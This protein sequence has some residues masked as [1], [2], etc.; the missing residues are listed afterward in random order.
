MNLSV[1]G[2]QDDL[3]V[4]GEGGGLGGGGVQAAALAWNP[5]PFDPPMI[6]VAVGGTVR[7]WEQERTGN[8]WRSVGGWEGEAGGGEV[9]DVAW[10][11]NMGRSYHL[12][13]TA[14]KD[15]TVRVY[16]WRWEEKGWVHACVGILKGHGAQVWRVSWNSSGSMLASTGDDGCTRIWKSDYNLQWKQIG[17]TVSQSRYQS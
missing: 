6:A 13:A 4:G 5:S 10:A 15:G 16:T 1:W 2:L 3:N 11:P 7:I 8:K 14:G 9:N 12:I 17:V